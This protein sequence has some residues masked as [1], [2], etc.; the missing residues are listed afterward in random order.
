MYATWKTKSYETTKKTLTDQ[1][2]LISLSFCTAKAKQKD[3][4]TSMYP[5][6]Y[7]IA[8]KTILSQKKDFLVLSFTIWGCQF[9]IYPTHV[10]PCIQ[11]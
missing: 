7:V 3:A 6:I 8:V 1:F 10:Y 9:V 11:P 4:N 5:S 2:L